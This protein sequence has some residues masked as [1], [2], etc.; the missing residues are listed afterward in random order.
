MRDS[1]RRLLERY[2]CQVIVD[3][4]GGRSSHNSVTMTLR[5]RTRIPMKEP[6]LSACLGTMIVMAQAQLGEVPNSCDLCSGETLRPDQEI[7][8]IQVPCSE[9]ALNAS[10][11]STEACATSLMPGF[12]VSSFCCENTEA[13][14]LC[15]LCSEE[16]QIILTRLVH[17][18]QYGQVT[19]AAMEKAA[20][21]AISSEVCMSLQQEAASYCCL[22]MS[23]SELPPCE[24]LCPNGAPPADL[25]KSDPVTGYTCSGLMLEYS[26]FADGE[27]CQDSAASSLGFDG[28]AFCCPDVNPPQK[29]STCGSDQELLYPERILFLYQDNSC[30]TLDKSLSYVVGETKCLHMLAESRAE[31]NCQCRPLRQQA[32]PPPLPVEE[33]NGEVSSLSASRQGMRNMLL[34]FLIG[35]QSIWMFH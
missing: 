11:L 32:F 17:S 5:K 26:R 12:D 29:C 9:A 20:S 25:S 30:V 19:C 7:P 21:L 1:E 24:L 3:L 23:N 14:N 13:P 35:I 15:S 28:V 33:L 31:N 10:Q 6:V 8:L 27:Q 18:E 2:L 22:D 34:L 16:E 4:L